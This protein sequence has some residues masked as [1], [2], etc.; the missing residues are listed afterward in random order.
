M[1]KNPKFRLT[2]HR[3]TLRSL[4]TPALLNAEGGAAGL[5]GTETVTCPVSCQGTCELPC[6]LTDRC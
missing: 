5:T 1:K 4:T 3:E 6:T 2:L